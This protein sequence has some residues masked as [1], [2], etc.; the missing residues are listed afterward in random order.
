MQ[1]N[2]TETM[3]I[4]IGNRVAND[5][6]DGA[7]QQNLALYREFIYQLTVA[8]KPKIPVRLS[9]RIA[10][11]AAAASIAATAFCLFSLKSTPKQADV[12]IPF[13]VGPGRVVG[14]IG[15]WI[16]S[17]SKE[18]T[19]LSFENGT[20][21]LLKRGASAQVVSSNQKSVQISLK[22][23]E[24]DANVHGN[25]VT[26]WS[27]E[28][29]P[30]RVN[31]VGTVFTVV[32]NQ[33]DEIIDV[34]VDRGTVIVQGAEIGNR[35]IQVS[36]G[37]HFRAYQK[38]G[39]NA[40]MPINSHYYNPK[41]VALMST[42]IDRDNGTVSWVDG[43]D[44]EDSVVS[45]RPEGGAE[46]L[47]ND[48]RAQADAF[49]KKVSRSTR[50]NMSDNLRNPRKSKAAMS[51]TKWLIY[52]KRAQYA[53]ALEEAEKLGIE[54]LLKR[55]DIQN[56]WKLAHAAYAGGRDDIAVKTLIAC[57]SRF[58]S[59][60]KAK[61]SA[62]LLGRIYFDQAG[63]PITASK[64]FNTYLSEDPEGYYAEEALGRLIVIFDRNKNE[65]DAKRYAQ[66]YLKK[67]PNGIFKENA[68]LV[69]VN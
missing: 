67:Y 9:T 56:L 20:G 17:P 2:E 57:R 28:A 11:L 36:G 12:D 47:S 44:V 50:R 39:L 27:I 35:G 65:M 8:D 34:K 6:G 62:F 63:D 1:S 18:D 30:F 25:G 66:D 13:R 24:L 26:E 16:D 15:R 51:K 37:H 3:F 55:L 40:Q 46:K 4:R 45:S 64:W 49:Y 52:Y 43:P 59:H 32:W 22:G 42:K 14:V 41:A 23:G 7:A 60:R 31:V 10:L 58:G 38:T 5:V 54:S 68:R 21:I 69:F 29:G 33:H 53:L 19:V 48:H 61:T